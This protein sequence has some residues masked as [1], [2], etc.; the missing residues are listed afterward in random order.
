MFLQLRIILLLLIL[1]LSACSSS[2]APNNPIIET[3]L[4]PSTNVSPPASAPVEL[5]AE[6]TE[7]ES[8]LGDKKHSSAKSRYL[9]FALLYLPNRIL[10]LL[11]VVRFDI[12]VG[13]AS[14][15]VLRLTRWGQFGMRSF[16][17]GS[18]RIG[19]RGR[20]LPFFLERTSEFGAG[21]G[22]LNS[23]ERSV[24]PVE[25]GGSV[26]IFLLGISAGLSVDEAVDFLFGIFGLDIYEDDF[27]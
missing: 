14:G 7:Y 15:A 3:D 23:K 9:R 5:G 19:L 2:S 24:T 10:D 20:K 17:P 21:P 8:R 6:Y 25:V 26:D 13:P 27:A 4:A 22:F 18:L 11:D 12:G 1:F 16:S